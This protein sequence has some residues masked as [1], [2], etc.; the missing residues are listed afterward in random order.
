MSSRA[1]R[2]SRRSRLG[3]QRRDERR[4]SA[5]IAAFESSS[6]AAG[7]D[8]IAMVGDAIERRSAQACR[9]SGSSTMIRSGFIFAWLN[10]FGARIIAVAAAALNLIWMRFVAFQVVIPDVLLTHSLNG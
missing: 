9:A 6:V 2:S 1:F 3:L 5:V 10:R 4:L 7:L 8:D